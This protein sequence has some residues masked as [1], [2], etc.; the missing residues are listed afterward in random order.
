MVVTSYSVR[1]KAVYAS[2]EGG[3]AADVGGGKMALM[4]DCHG[5]LVR[6]IARM[7]IPN[8]LE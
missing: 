7:R 1:A 5:F 6:S 8:V 2:F 4:A 3:G